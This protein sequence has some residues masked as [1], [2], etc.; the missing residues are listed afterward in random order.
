MQKSK[1]YLKNDSVK[2]SLNLAVWLLGFILAP[3]E[4]GFDSSTGIQTNKKRLLSWL[5]Q[6]NIY[7]WRQCVFIVC[8]DMSF[9]APSQEWW[10][11]S[12]RVM[13]CWMLSDWLLPS[14]QPPLRPSALLW[15]S[16]S[17]C[18][19]VSLS[20]HHGQSKHKRTLPV[21]LTASRNTHGFSPKLYSEQC[22]FYYLHP[23][24][25]CFIRDAC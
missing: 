4:S 23:K 19:P 14:Q 21:S 17:D 12:E 25:I 7:F 1:H 6:G 11:Y 2:S 5:R 18:I 20:W 22:K 16:V 3:P 15:S 24:V 13:N 9:D 10:L 8:Q